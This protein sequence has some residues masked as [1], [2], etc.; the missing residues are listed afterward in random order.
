MLID[1]AMYNSRSH[2]A[3]SPVIQAV[4][5]VPVERLPWTVSVIRTRDNVS[6]DL[7]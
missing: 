1:A 4:N 2:L 5:C 7:E 6:V 3:S